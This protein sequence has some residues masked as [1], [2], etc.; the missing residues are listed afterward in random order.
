MG[1]VYKVRYGHG[2]SERVPSFP[3]ASILWDNKSKNLEIKRISL[4][5]PLQPLYTQSYCPHCFSL[6]HPG[7]SEVGKLLQLGIK[8]K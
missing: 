1:E 6:R 4:Y 2:R 5:V 8:F 7:S 3:T